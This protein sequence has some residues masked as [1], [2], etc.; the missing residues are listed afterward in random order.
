M[1]FISKRYACRVAKT[2]RGDPDFDN[3]TDITLIVP[4]TKSRFKTEIN[5]SLLLG[6]EQRANQEDL[7]SSPRCEKI[8][9][10]PT[11]KGEAGVNYVWFLV[12][13]FHLY[14][15]KASQGHVKNNIKIKP[16]ENYIE[17]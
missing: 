2:T 15:G 7:S 1:R 12:V 17:I 11:E 9:L 13:H 8:L 4:G 6:T 16:A 10:R 3:F 5:N 14:N